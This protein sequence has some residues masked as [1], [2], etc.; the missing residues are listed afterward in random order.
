[1][2]SDQNIFETNDF[3]ELNREINRRN[4]AGFGLWILEPSKPNKAKYRAR[5]VK[6][7]EGK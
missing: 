4:E 6:Q 5:F 1:M 7:K 2:N 3:D